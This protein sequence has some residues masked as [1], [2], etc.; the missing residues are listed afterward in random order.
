MK[1]VTRNGMIAV[2]AASGAMAVAAPASAAFAAPGAS[3]D[4]AAVGS[5]GLI[6]GDTAQ[7]PVHA[8]VIVC[9]NTVNVVGLL[10]PGVGNRCANESGDRSAR[11]LGRG[12]VRGG[13]GAHG[14]AEARGAGSAHRGAATHG[15][16]GAQR[17]A[18]THEGA[19]V[20]GGAIASGGGIDS[21]GVLSGNGLQ[22]PLHLPVNLTGNSVNVVGVGNAVVG[23]ESVNLPGGGPT[24]PDRP[25][26]PVRPAR[27][28]GPAGG[29]PRPATGPA[30]APHGRP[31]RHG[32]GPD[33]AR[34]PGQCRARPGGA[35]V[36]RRYRPQAV[37]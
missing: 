18:G 6:S 9:G 21:A 15:G 27:Q 13:A 4:G 23:N 7:L 16:A 24:V 31:R 20:S 10:N 2:A 36:Y 26:R 25:D 11:G 3:A 30:A 28:A 19:S 29:A 35:V 12:D 1:R 8:P 5:P 37:R 32:S 33:R 14:G 17:G 34:R 22:L